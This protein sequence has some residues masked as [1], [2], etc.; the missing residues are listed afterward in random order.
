[1]LPG[2]QNGHF[3][4]RNRRESSDCLAEIR[5][6]QGGGDRWDHREAI[7]FPARVPIEVDVLFDR[8]R[9]CPGKSGGIF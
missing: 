4:I 6:R 3:N 5:V 9:N 8:V 7:L 1:M 2:L